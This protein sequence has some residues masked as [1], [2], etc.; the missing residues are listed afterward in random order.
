M[1][2]QKQ[3]PM[4]KAIAELFEI[5]N[6]SGMATPEQLLATAEKYEVEVWSL[7]GLYLDAVDASA[8]E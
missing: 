1:K 2:K 3:T 7:E 4:Q 6:G 5:Q 8:D